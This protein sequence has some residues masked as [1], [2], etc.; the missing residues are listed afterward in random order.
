MPKKHKEQIAAT[1]AYLSPGTRYLLLRWGRRSGKTK[2]AS[3]IAFGEALQGKAVL[4]L[5]P[6]HKHAREAWRNL[7]LLARQLPPGLAQFNEAEKVLKTVSGGMTQILSVKDPHSVRSVGVHLA[8]LDEV[9][10]IRHWEETWQ[11]VRPALS[12]YRG[13][14][15]FISTPWGK[16]HFYDLW[17]SHEDD[18]RW[19]LSHMPSWENPFLPPDEVE[20]ARRDL[21]DLLFRQEYGAEFVDVEGALFKREWL[22]DWADAAPP[23]EELAAQAR[24]WDIAISAEGDYTVGAKVALDKEGRVWVLDVVRGRWD[25]PTVVET[26]RE[27]ALRDGSEVMQGIEAVGVQ[28]GVWQTLEREPALANTPLFPVQARTDKVTRALPLLSRAKAGRLV[29]L[30]RGWTQALVDELLAF[31]LGEHDDQVDA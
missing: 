29:L 4:W 28:K 12:D 15:I 20:D 1:R 19:W 26:I 9:A 31:P 21:P 5:A 22:M 16:N 30:R 10:F 13:K 6:E 11:A 23:K 24:G 27:T 3:E 2:W 18:P 7:H 25:W 14:A 8:V 17:V